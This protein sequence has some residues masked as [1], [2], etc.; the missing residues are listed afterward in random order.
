MPV[1]A[2]GL[3]DFDPPRHA[4][5]PREPNSPNPFLHTVASL[6]IGK[7]GKDFRY[8]PGEVFG[9]N[10]ISVKIELGTVLEPG[11]AF[12]IRGHRRRRCRR[13]LD[14]HDHHADQQARAIQRCRVPL[15]RP[16]GGR[17]DE[18][19]V[20]LPFCDALYLDERQAKSLA[21]PNREFGQGLPRLSRKAPSS[22]AARS[23]FESFTAGLI[24]FRDR[25]SFINLRSIDRGY[26]PKID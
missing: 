1:P 15:T 21:H 23:T 7:R 12:Y 26:Q 19:G 17:K 24:D 14:A 20:A 18:A 10:E 16:V 2:F 8:R 13:S 5:S 3:P 25:R 9:L 6:R 11:E 4:A 22:I